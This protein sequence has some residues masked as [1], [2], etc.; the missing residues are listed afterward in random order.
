MT[1][2]ERVKLIARKRGLSLVSINDSANLGKN[3][4]YKWKTQTPNSDAL[5]SVA[6]V[7]NVSTDYLL[8]NT[9]EMIPNKK[10][11]SKPEE[12]DLDAALENKGVVMRFQGKELSDKAKRGILDIIKLV[13]GDED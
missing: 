1:L 5:K 2:F 3:A 4:I 9:D 10:G 8:G 13:D 6:K 11:S 7:L 12:I